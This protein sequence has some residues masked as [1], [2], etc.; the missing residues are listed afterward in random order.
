MNRLK[1]KFKE[2]TGLDPKIKLHNS[3]P[4]YNPK[5][6]EWLEEQQ[7]QTQ[8]IIDELFEVTDIDFEKWGREC[9]TFEIMY[10]DEAE[11]IVDTFNKLMVKYSGKYKLF[12]KGY[13]NS[14]NEDI[15]ED[16]QRI[17]QKKDIEQLISIINSRTF[18]IG[19][20]SRH[21]LFKELQT[22]AIKHNISI[23]TTQQD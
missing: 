11:V 22:I 13:Y 19:F 14:I 7:H 4:E 21:R 5:Y 15:S 6:V 18:D 3:R 16:S 2:E 8:N 23:V 20:T 12:F 10:P 1:I 9:R 17:I